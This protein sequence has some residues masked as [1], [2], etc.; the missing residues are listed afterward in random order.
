MSLKDSFNKNKSQAVPNKPLVQKNSND[1][2]DLESENYVKEFNKKSNNFLLDIDYSDPTNFAKF[3]LAR[4][5]YE[6]IVTRITDF[7]PYDGSKYEQLKFENE[8]NPLEKYVFNYEYPKSTGYVEFG[9]TWAGTSTKNSGFG[10]S[11]APEYIK[12]VNQTK[13]NI[14]DPTNLRRENTRFIPASGSTIE[15]WMKK[16]AFPN[17][18]TQTEAECVFYTKTSDSNKLLMIYITGSSTGSFIVNYR[19]SNLGSSEIVTIP[20]TLTT[21]A[22]STWHHHAFVFGTSSSKINIDY[23]LDGN[24]KNSTTSSTAVTINITG[25]SLC[26]I[27]ALGGKLTAAG[28]DLIG[29]GKLSGSIDEFR[30][31]NSKRTGKDIG[32]NY[33]KNVGGGS[34][35]D[36]ANVSLGIY[37]KFNEGITNTSSIDSVILDYS[38]RLNNGNFI[39][40]NST[41]RSTGSAITITTRNTETGVPIIYYNHPDVQTFLNNKLSLADSH[42]YSNNFNLKS[43]LP[44]WIVEDDE[45]N[46]ETLINFTHAL[47]SY[48]DTLYLQI[49]K[50][51]DLK[52][53]NYLQY[54]GSEP[55]FN[56]LLLTSNGFEAPNL[57]ISLDDISTIASQ[58]KEKEYTVLLND[59]KNLIYKNIYNNLDLIYKSKGTE[60]SFKNLI[61]AFGADEDLY[62]LN[63]YS[64]KTTYQLSDTYINRSIKKDI[65]DQTKNRYSENA[66]SVFY[67]YSSSADPNSTSFITASTPIS[68]AICFENNFYFSPKPLNQYET[69]SE[70]STTKTFSLFGIRQASNTENTL[71]NVSPDS[72]SFSVRYLEKDDKVYFQLYSNKYGINLTSSY[73][74]DFYENNLWNISFQVYQSKFLTNREYLVKFS[75]YSFIDDN[76]FRSFELSSSI[77]Q[78][79]GSDFFSSNKRLYVG[80][81]RADTIGNLIYGCNHKI[82]SSRVWMDYLSPEELKEHS[83]NPNNFG[84]K[85]PSRNATIGNGTYIPK[86]ETL[87]LNWDYSN[88]T[89][90]NS[91]GEVYYVNDLT[92]GSSNVPYSIGIL[93]GSKS[94]TYFAAGYGFEES[95]TIKSKELIYGQEQQDP[96]NIISS[97]LV[98]IL[99]TNDDYYTKQERPAKYFFAVETSMYDII[100]KNM[101]NFFS[102]IVEFN[103]LIADPVSEY[104]FQYK[105]LDFFRRIFFEKVKN[106]IDLEKYV[107]IYK[108]IDDALDGILMNLIPASANSAEKARTIVENTILQRNKVRKQFYLKSF[109]NYIKDPVGGGVGDE[110]IYVGKT[111]INNGATTKEGVK[112]GGTPAK[113]S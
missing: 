88:V 35:S 40:Y 18:S 74:D 15:F 11:S 1:F 26:T 86:L 109:I 44:S 22:D 99:E 103:N 113:S 13:N 4:K 65:I 67:I 6:N 7:Y 32:L 92:S 105:D 108:W 77:N 69:N 24:Y 89:S 25:S 21:L 75:G 104:R 48:L 59:L 27:G 68:A 31:W 102:S 14:Y 39:G 28:N 64:D 37:F 33:F 96:E 81:E 78:A 41:S 46:G 10:S 76:I 29:Y 51:K 12:F 107:G 2:G 93:S 61:K 106:T 80:A 45:Q 91:S 84:R 72:A 94:K 83:K 85:N 95:T 3:G 79:S 63:V 87:I 47:S 57:F 82:A 34:N 53:K 54:S 52:N 70:K 55:G 58:N 16:N 9:R 19:Y 73:F 98:N 112:L 110:Y 111:D 56:D 49:D 71:T 60:K 30:F 101:L 23:Y 66:G 62:K 100:S 38:G 42:D 5:Y 17:A 8:L 43:L 36:D 20:T 97:N 50:F 90:S